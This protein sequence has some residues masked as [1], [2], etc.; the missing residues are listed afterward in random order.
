MESY[1]YIFTHKFNS[2]SLKIH[3][4]VFVCLFVYRKDTKMWKTSSTSLTTV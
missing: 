4:Q 1:I 3:K 2:L